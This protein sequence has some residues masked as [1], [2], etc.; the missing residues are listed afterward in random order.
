MRPDFFWLGTGAGATTVRSGFAN[1]RRIISYHGR[2]N[3]IKPVLILKPQM[4]ADKRR[5]EEAFLKNLRRAPRVAATCTPPF[6]TS[7]SAL[8][9][10]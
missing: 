10:D 3:V 5:W 9:R 8:A 6:R 2:R 1:I 7:E 4:D